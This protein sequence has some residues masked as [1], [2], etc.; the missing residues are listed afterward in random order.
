MKVRGF[1]EHK[2]ILL[3]NSNNISWYLVIFYSLFLSC[4][5][6]EQCSINSA[7]NEIVE[8]LRLEKSSKITYS[9]CPP[10][11]NIAH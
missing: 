3:Q 11:T 2:Q 9:K 5:S 6:E 4:K 8:S 1:L 7:V 10:A